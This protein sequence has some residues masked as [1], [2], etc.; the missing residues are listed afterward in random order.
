MILTCYPDKLFIGF[1]TICIGCLLS[2]G[3]FVFA[4]S[5]ARKDML[6]AASACTGFFLLP[7]MFVG[8]EL[9]VE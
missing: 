1:Y 5:Q 9:A 4:D 3:F 7:M 2:L 6:C 8:Y